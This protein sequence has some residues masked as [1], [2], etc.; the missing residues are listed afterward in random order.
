MLMDLERKVDNIPRLL[1]YRTA[2]DENV[3]L[4]AGWV[5]LECE[6][7]YPWMKDRRL[8]EQIDLWMTYRQDAD[9]VFPYYDYTYLEA[10]LARLS[11][12]TQ[13]FQTPGSRPTGSSTAKPPTTSA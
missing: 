12:L 13:A 4:L 9:I 8:T 5:G 1:D 2:P 10:L 6:K 11:G 3:E 7:N